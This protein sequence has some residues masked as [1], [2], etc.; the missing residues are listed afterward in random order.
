VTVW[1]WLVRR[2]ADPQPF[3]SRLSAIHS[4]VCDAAECEGNLCSKAGPRGGH[5][6]EWPEHSHHSA[7]H[8]NGH[9]QSLLKWFFTGRVKF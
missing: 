8:H 1:S 2:L 9:M 3:V 7:R 4:A 5:T 6:V